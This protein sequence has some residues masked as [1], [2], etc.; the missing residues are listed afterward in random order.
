[1]SITT[2]NQ[3]DWIRGVNTVIQEMN[4]KIYRQALKHVK[5][6][7]TPT[8]HAHRLAT[9][10]FSLVEREANTGKTNH[11]IAYATSGQ[12]QYLNAQRF[13][14]QRAD[15]Y[16]V[17]DNAFTTSNNTPR[18]ILMSRIAQVKA[19]ARSQLS[20]GKRNLIYN[21]GTTINCGYS[22]QYELTEAP[23]VGDTITV[24]VWGTLGTNR[25]GMIGVFNSHGY[26]ELFRL[27][28]VAEGVYQGTGLW[29]HPAL[30]DS[31]AHLRF[32][33]H[34]RLHNFPDDNTINN[35]FIKV[36][37]EYGSTGTAWTPAPEEVDVYP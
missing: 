28:K 33:T 32:N 11:V 21:S 34:L 13:Y 8:A 25:T 16:A 29:A 6:S 5:T 31:A 37:M 3:V 10:V 7:N 14:D 9:G 18:D 27:T 15:W 4:H 35:A 12:V 26:T 1:M 2:D 20:A 22:T 30:P 17:L 36:K 23:N 24:T 19:E